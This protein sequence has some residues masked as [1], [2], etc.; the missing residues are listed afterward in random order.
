MKLA[1]M[2]LAEAAVVTNDTLHVTGGFWDGLDATRF[3]ARHDVVVVLA[4]RPR[5]TDVGTPFHLDIQ[6]TA[7]DGS[8]AA[9]H[10]GD[11]VI[12]KYRQQAAFPVTVAATF[13]VAGEY[14]LRFT[15]SFGEDELRFQ[16][17][18]ARTADQ[19]EGFAL[20]LGRA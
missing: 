20:G 11:L 16:V 2:F 12:N 9:H 13:P 8:S 5:L 10:H 19:G 18:S 6:V 3:P 14:R 7:P 4:V 17:V 1:N 15:S